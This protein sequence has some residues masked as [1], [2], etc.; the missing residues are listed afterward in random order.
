MK[1]SDFMKPNP[2]ETGGEQE[3]LNEVYLFERMDLG[4][5]NNIFFHYLLVKL[6][7]K[8]KLYPKQT[9]LGSSV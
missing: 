3:F 8:S 9:F 2:W 6:S 1:R 5:E 4:L 7:S